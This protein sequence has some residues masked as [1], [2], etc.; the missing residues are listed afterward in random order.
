MTMPQE[1]AISGMTGAFR[2]WGNTSA[3][4]SSAIFADRIG[5]EI[6]WVK[7]SEAHRRRFRWNADEKPL[8]RS[9]QLDRPADKRR[10]IHF[11]SHASLY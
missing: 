8:D 7:P 1:P 3:V 4:S 5:A 10:Q 2:D 9:T 6:D 11:P